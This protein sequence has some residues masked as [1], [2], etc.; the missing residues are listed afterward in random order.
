MAGY[1]LLTDGYGKSFNLNLTNDG[2]PP[3]VKFGKNYLINY[4]KYEIGN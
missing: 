2:R 1:G 3:I 4:R